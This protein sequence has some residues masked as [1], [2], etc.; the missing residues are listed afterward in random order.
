MMGKHQRRGEDNHEGEDE[1][2]KVKRD[3]LLTRIRQYFCLLLLGFLQMP[4]VGFLRLLRPHRTQHFHTLRA[5]ISA[6]F[7]ERNGKNEGRL[8]V[9]VL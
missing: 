9:L 5:P 1:L 7:G 2:H 3:A 6:L 8:A 4:P